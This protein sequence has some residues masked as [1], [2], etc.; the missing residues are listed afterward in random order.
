MTIKSQYTPKGSFAVPGTNR[1]FSPDLLSNV[2]TQLIALDFS[3]TL[4]TLW[5]Y[6]GS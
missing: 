5:G 3:A 2:A 1:A 6:T 4:T